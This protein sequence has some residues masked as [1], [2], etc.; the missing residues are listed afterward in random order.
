MDDENEIEAPMTDEDYKIYV[1]DKKRELL[2]FDI[3]IGKFLGIGW[4]K[5][6]E[7]PL[8][9]DALKLR[10]D[11]SHLIY[12]KHHRDSYA[13]RHERLEAIKMYEEEFKLKWGEF[14]TQCTEYVLNSN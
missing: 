1:H 11:K 14:V 4:K 5:K 7:D 9:M 12:I 6:R 13:S 8:V 3:F 2:L 10:Q